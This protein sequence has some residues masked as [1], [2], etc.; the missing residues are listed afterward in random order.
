MGAD[1]AAIA[2]L[3]V[4]ADDAVGADLDVVADARVRRG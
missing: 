1:A 3:D 4:L 2:D